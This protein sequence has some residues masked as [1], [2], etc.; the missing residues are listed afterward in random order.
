MGRR[1]RQAIFKAKISILGESMLYEL[2]KDEQII[3]CTND[4]NCIEPYEILRLEQKA[5]YKFKLN[6]NFVSLKKIKEYI[7]KQKGR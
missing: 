4:V 6:G 5:G 1:S 3:V 7:E 2:W